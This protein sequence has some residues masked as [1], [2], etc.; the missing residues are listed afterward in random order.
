[1]AQGSTPGVPRTAQVLFSGCSL[2]LLLPAA[3]PK[4][5]VV[6]FLRAESSPDWEEEMK[7][8]WPRTRGTMLEGHRP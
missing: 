4:S 5:F 2:T 6:F 3:K 7:A 8:M 1:M